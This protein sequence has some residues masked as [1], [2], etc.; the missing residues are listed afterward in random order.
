MAAMEPDRQPTADFPALYFIWLSQEEEG[1]FSQAFLLLLLPQLGAFPPPPGRLLRLPRWKLSTCPSDLAEHS[2]GFSS[3]LARLSG[4]QWHL[5]IQ[6]WPS[7]FSLKLHKIAK[8]DLHSVKT[9]CSQGGVVT[10]SHSGPFSSSFHI[11]LKSSAT[12]DISAKEDEVVNLNGGG[13]QPQ[14][15][16]LTALRSERGQEGRRPENDKMETNIPNSQRP[17]EEVVKNPTLWR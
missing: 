16:A 12:W 2:P 10:D 13:W 1:R 11:M 6:I 15:G 4:T 3:S 14:S 5:T 7:D 8:K 17:F 9:N